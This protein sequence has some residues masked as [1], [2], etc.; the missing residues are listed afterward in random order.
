[1]R[2]CPAMRLRVIAIIL[3]TVAVALL[4][5]ICFFLLSSGLLNNQQH[6]ATTPFPSSTAPQPSPT[7][8]QPN[9]GIDSSVLAALLGLIGVVV[10]ALIA[11]GFSL[12]QARYNAKLQRK[13][14]LLQ[15]QLT[16]PPLP[17][18]RER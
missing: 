3:M 12:Y 9:G 1:M 15:H 13:N 7:S 8:Q 17:P 18:H 14:P 10:G 2:R 6:V 5:W 4:I 16:T 11:G